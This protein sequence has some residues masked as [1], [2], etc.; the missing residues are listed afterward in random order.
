MIKLYLLLNFCA[1]V[2]CVMLG[3]DTE[4]QSLAYLPATFA[5]KCKNPWVA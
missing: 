1:I 5:G 4:S 2:V 3:T